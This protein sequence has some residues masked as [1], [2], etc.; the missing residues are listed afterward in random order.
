MRAAR[1]AARYRAKFG[2]DAVIDVV[3]FRRHGHNELD[4]PSFT[5]PAM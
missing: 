1:L 2:E 5:N 3:G 4:E